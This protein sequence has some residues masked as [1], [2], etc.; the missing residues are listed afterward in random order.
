MSQLDD[1]SWHQ[2]VLQVRDTVSAVVPEHP[3]PIE[4]P[5]E[6]Q[7]FRL[8][9]ER[10]GSVPHF[11]FQPAESTDDARFGSR[12]AR[13]RSIAW[14]PAKEVGGNDSETFSV[15]NQLLDTALSIERS[16]REQF[17]STFEQLP[18]H[19]Y[20]NP[21][22][23]KCLVR[24]LHGE[25]PRA[26]SKRTH[27]FIQPV[28][29]PEDSK[30]F[31]DAS[32]FSLTNFDLLDPE[33]PVQFRHPRASQLVVNPSSSD[34]LTGVALDLGRVEEVRVLGEIWMFIRGEVGN[35]NIEGDC[36]VWS[37]QDGVWMPREV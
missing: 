33:P 17:E 11:V 14:E 4:P 28:R 34:G 2:A 19:V 3:I 31:L 22:A 24:A 26:C 6:H 1:E 37:W 29:S 35:C 25:G 20:Y 10:I 18:V 27:Q 32:H 8:E 16:F 23:W 30:R 21:E 9:V 13:T 7:V 15:L 5:E 12:E 36:Q